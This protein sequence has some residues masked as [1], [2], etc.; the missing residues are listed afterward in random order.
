MSRYAV[1]IGLILFCGLAYWQT[2]Q[3]DRVPP[4]L[5]RGMQPADFPQLVLWLI[6][7]LSVIL[8]IQAWRNGPA[9][10]KAENGSEDLAQA[11]SPSVWKTMGLFLVFAALA[12]VDLFLGLGAFALCLAALWGERRIWALMLVAL[13]SPALVFLLFDQ[14]FEVR[15]PRGLLTNFWYG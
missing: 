12:P 2:T 9:A 7:G 4:I 14:V 8:L 13:I 6:V 1:P 5:L 3:F 15:F 10:P 11:M